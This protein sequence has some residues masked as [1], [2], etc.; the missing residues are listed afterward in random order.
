MIRITL[1]L[2]D[3]VH[4]RLIARAA[5]DRRSLNSQIVHLLECALD[6]AETHDESP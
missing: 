3:E 4:A 1:R 5:T 6:A 2:P